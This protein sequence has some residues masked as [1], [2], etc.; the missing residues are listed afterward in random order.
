LAENLYGFGVLVLLNQPDA[1]PVRYLLVGAAS[2]DGAA[3]QADS[4]ADVASALTGE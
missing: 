1:E 3:P 2:G 4:T